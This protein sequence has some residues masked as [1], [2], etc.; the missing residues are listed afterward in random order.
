MKPRILL[1]EDDPQIRRFLRTSLGVQ[2]YEL[3]EAG[4][5]NEG[6]ALAASQV[7]DVIILDLGLPDL[8]GI[9]VIRRLREWS[10]MPIIILSAR[11]QERDKVANLDAGVDDYLTSP[12]WHGRIAGA[13]S[14]GLK[15]ETP[16]GRW[17][18]CTDFYPGGP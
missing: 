5:G 3:I 15:K 16:C 18:T 4:T 6:L 17:Q 9:E 14:G 10:S 11:G 1:I 13:H 8:E 7:P 12:L 2:G